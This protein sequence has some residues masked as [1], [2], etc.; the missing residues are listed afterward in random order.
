MTPPDDLPDLS[1][2][3][4]LLYVNDAS[5][6]LTGGVLFEY[7]EWKRVGGRQFLQGRIP[8][9]GDAE[10]VSSLQAGI[11]WDAV[12]HYVLFSS[13]E[14]YKN[15]SFP[16]RPPTLLQRVFGNNGG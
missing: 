2:K 13:R 7:P 11:A 8:E 9:I 6:A 1:G 10:W 3:L 5:Q 4:V 15:R 16:N 14:D 12:V